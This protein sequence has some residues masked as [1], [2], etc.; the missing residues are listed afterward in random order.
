M[1]QYH[2]ESVDSAWQDHQ[3]KQLEATPDSTTG[4]MALVHSSM[5]GLDLDVDRKPLLRSHKSYPYALRTSRTNIH[6]PDT[7]PLNSSD[8]SPTSANPEGLGISNLHDSQ[9]NEMTTVTFGGSTLR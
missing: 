1:S 8:G 2:A 6:E 7:P 9:P 3:N 5:P 4:E